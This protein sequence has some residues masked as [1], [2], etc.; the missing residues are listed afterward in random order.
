[1][2]QGFGSKSSYFY[3][4]ER[5][6]DPFEVFCSKYSPKSDDVFKYK[7]IG[8]EDMIEPPKKTCVTQKSSDSNMWINVKPIELKESKIAQNL[9]IEVSAPKGSCRNPLEIDKIIEPMRKLKSEETFKEVRRDV[10]NK[11]IFRIIR[12]FFHSMLEKLVPDYKY[13]KK[14]NLMSMLASFSE[15]LFPTAENILEVTE[16][17][18]ALMF[19]REILLIKRTEDQRKEIQVFLDVQSKY[20]HKLL[21]TVFASKSFRVIFQYFVENGITYFEEDENVIK[22]V[23]KYTEELEKLKEIH[24][25]HKEGLFAN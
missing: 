16:V 1:M 5:L 3:Q 24:Y 13:Q 2:D 22:N 8:F 15:Y 23:S 7:N 17:L 19:R 4:E 25:R 21:P 6:N 18:S 9:K 12:R 10:I 14:N 11:T 20:T